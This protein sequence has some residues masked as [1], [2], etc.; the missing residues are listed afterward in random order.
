MYFINYKLEQFCRHY[1]LNLKKPV[2][3]IS[4]A[5]TLDGIF[6]CHHYWPVIIKIKACLP[7]P[8]GTG[9]TAAMAPMIKPVIKML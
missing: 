6:S 7:D 8:L 4:Q 5:F 9:K 1:R 2:V 3:V